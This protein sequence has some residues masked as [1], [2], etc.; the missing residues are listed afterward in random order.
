MDLGLWI[1]LCGLHIK[2]GLEIMNWLQHRDW[3][4]NV[5]Y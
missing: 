1:M 5:E 4:L 3:V 2:S